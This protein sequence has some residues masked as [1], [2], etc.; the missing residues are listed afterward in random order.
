LSDCKLGDS[1]LLIRRQRHLI[2][3]SHGLGW[4]MAVCDTLR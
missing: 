2:D 4:A 1:A 3:G